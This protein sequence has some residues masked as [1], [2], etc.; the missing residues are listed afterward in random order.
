MKDLRKLTIAGC[1]H[2][3][4]ASG[5]EVFHVT[6]PHAVMQAVGYL[7]HTAEAWERIYMRGQG[8]LYGALAP[9]LYRGITNPMTQGKRHA[10]LTKVIN[11][12]EAASSL[13]K[14]MPDYAKEPLLQHYGI[15]TTWLDIVDNIWVALWF[16]LHRAYV[17]GPE[18]QYMHF[19]PRTV[20][21]DGEFG[22]ILLI[23]TED[24]RR[25]R[26]RKGVAKGDQTEV[27]D[28][29]I[30]APSVFLRPHAQ[31]GLLF[32]ARGTEGGRATDYASALAGIIRFPLEAGKQW[33]GVGSMHDVRS[34]FPP[35]FYDSGYQILL[36]IELTEQSLGVITH[37]GA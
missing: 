2:V 33:L 3:T 28:L 11:D 7:K 13:F 30:A 19:D 18:K 37:I 32:R 24:S 34:L 29:R 8:R 14:A 26:V 27:I 35:P 4:D 36:G 10:A 21:T 20:A 6:T 1:Q 25:E 9:T 5:H 31:H 17:S 12:F 15:Q 16:A 22:Y 23:R